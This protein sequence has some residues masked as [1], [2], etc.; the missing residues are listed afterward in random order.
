MMIELEIDGKKVRAAQGSMIIEAADAAGFDIPRFCYH[1]K[2][3]IAANCR[4]CLVE[5]DKVR[6]PVPAC[7]TPVT[8]GMQVFTRSAMALDAQKAVMEFLLINHPLDCPICDQGGECELQDLSLGYG[9]DSS[10]FSEGK[11][12]VE[13]E[14]LGAL[15]ATEMTR[16]IQCTRC[17]RFGD[18]I[19]GLREL[20]GMGRGEHLEI[21][22]YVGHALK[23]ELSGNIID[24]C[25]VG[26]LT[27]KPFRFRARAWELEQ[28]AH[29]SPH[30]CVGSNIYIHTRKAIYSPRCEVMRVVP[31][32]NEAV[33][34]TWISD[35]DRFSY[36]GLNSP[37]RVETPL[38]K[39]KETG[40]WK[41]VDWQTALEFTAQGLKNIAAESGPE[42]IAALASPNCTTEEFYLLQKL[43]RAMGSHNIDHRI[44]QLDFSQQDNAALYPNLG[45]SLEDLENLEATLLVGANPRFDQ[46]LINHRIR[47]S[48]LQ[49]GQVMCINPVDFAFN[50]ELNTKVIVDIEN[51]VSVLAGISKALLNINPNPTEINKDQKELVLELLK[52]IK[53]SETELKIA[54]VLGAAKRSAVLLGSIA[55][56]HPQAGILQSLCELI[57]RLTQGGSC[58]YLSEGA[59]SAGAWLAGAVPHRA[60]VGGVMSPGQNARAMLI[61]PLQAYV[62][63]NIEPELDCANS[64]LALKALNNAKFVVA[65]NTFT[66]TTIQEYADVILPMAAFSET[67]GSYMNV[68]G[69]LQTFSSATLPP[70]EVRPG[71]K[72]LRV[73]GNFLGLAGFDYESA[74]EILEELKTQMTSKKLGASAFQ[75]V[76]PTNLPKVSGALTRVGTWPLYRVD[77]LVRRAPALQDISSGEEVGLVKVCASVAEQLGVNNGEKVWV[78]Q[79]T[80]QRTEEKR[81][82]RIILKLMIDEKVSKGS[83]LVYA[84]VGETVGLG[85]ALGPIFL[86]P[87]V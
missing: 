9:S 72:I 30:D 10:R 68:E 42:Q 48:V 41:A 54:D 26:A 27:S 82:F 29:V 63:V 81:D 84:G 16:C 3:T 19:A 44:R 22:T 70:A 59:N 61:D 23:S 53:P 58:G 4:M 24:L 34:E 2:L 71:W 38:I 21:G 7:A 20:G 8:S 18:E 45:V 79:G 83:V 80:E 62:L 13:N 60:P 56:N 86:E 39:D 73:L 28:H 47:K 67:Q 12:A 50:F 85:D 31:R 40:K 77:G 55:L 25:P 6:K 17:V 36:E 49:N 35:R 69:R 32:D 66:S 1:R 46:P 78:R 87:F 5:V 51:M 43:M 57:A 65:I 64:G 37:D 33:N 76:C 74:S 52:N 15:I 11:R 75:W 14:N